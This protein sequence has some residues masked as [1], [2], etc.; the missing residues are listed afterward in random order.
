MESLSID[1]IKEIMTKL[2]IE[3]PVFHLEADFQYALAWKLGEKLG[4]SKIRLEKSVGDKQ[5][6]DIVVNN[7]IFI[8][9]KYKTLKLN[10]DIK[11]PAHVKGE[12]FYLKDQSARDNSSY[13][14]WKDIERVQSKKGGYAIFLTND[15][16]YWESDCKG[17][18]DVNFSI[19][20]GREMNNIKEMNWYKP[21]L[22]VSK[23]AREKG[24]QVNINGSL[25]WQSYS[26]LDPQKKEGYI[27]DTF[28][29]LL[30]KI[31]SSGVSSK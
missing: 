20:K 10:E 2:S 14:F 28:K 18:S 5:Y 1:D 8:E 21:P 11:K 31:P 16:L 30:F 25:E 24:I 13:D 4:S 27:H 17:H 22:K 12:D 19:Y 15:H 29:Y 26:I 7:E 6:I 3:R 9:L 23:G